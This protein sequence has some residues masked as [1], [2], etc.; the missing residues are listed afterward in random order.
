[1]RR[2]FAVAETF[3][4]LTRR[5]LPAAEAIAIRARRALRL[6]IAFRGPFD[7]RVRRFGMAMLA[8]QAIPLGLFRALVRETGIHVIA[9]GTPVA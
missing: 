2:P 1:V 8:A 5:S 6:T 7:G 9:A 4:V 3:A